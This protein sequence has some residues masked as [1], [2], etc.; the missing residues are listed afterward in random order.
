MTIQEAISRGSLP[1]IDPKRMIGVCSKLGI[2]ASDLSFVLTDEQLRRLQ[3]DPSLHRTAVSAQV[4]GAHNTLISEYDELIKKYQALSERM[5]K[6][7]DLSSKKSEIDKIL[8]DLVTARAEYNGVVKN[9]FISKENMGFDQNVINPV[10][11]TIMGAIDSKLQKQGDKLSAEYA[12]LDKL[13]SNKFKTKFK[14]KRNAKRIQKVA[15]KIAKLQGKQGKLQTTQKKI[16]N[17]G[18]SKYAKIKSKEFLEYRNDLQ[19]YT[20]YADAKEKNVQAQRDYASDLA[21]TRAELH[22]LESQ[23]GNGNVIDRAKNV[24]AR[25]KLQFEQRKLKSDLGRYQRQEKI[26]ERLRNKKG[27]C[28]LSE[29]MYRQITM[30]YAM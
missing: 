16:V 30:S 20:A 4:K 23:I 22:N 29:Q 19:R 5:D 8:A 17:K 25:A 21:Q 9:V 1:N 10:N 18:S 28:R 15:E 7:P 6:S 12:K 2:P 13:Q 26:I 14:Q 27:M 24:A 11:R 3:Y